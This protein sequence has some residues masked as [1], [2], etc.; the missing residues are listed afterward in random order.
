MRSALLLAL[1]L[2]LNVQTHASGDLRHQIESA[3]SEWVGYTIPLAAGQHIE[4]CCSLYGDNVNVNTSDDALSDRASILYRI[5]DGRIE[6]IR[7]FTSCAIHAQVKWLEGVD[8]RASAE[9]L[10]AMAKENSSL[11]KRAVFALGLHEAGIDP[12]IDLARHAEYSKL[13]SE[14]LFWL[15]E[16]AARKAAGPLRDAVDNDPDEEV[17]AKAVFGIAQLPS[18]QSIPMLA[19]LMRMHRSRAVR[20]K[21]AFWLGQ[22]NDPRAVEAITDY[23]RQ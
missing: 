18:D 6:S 9:M 17:R 20:K 14:A 7:V 2:T 15:A 5:R 19:E 11:S 13:R 4:I 1:T 21:A 8:P 10:Y 22:K 3:G 12:L 23:L 16:F